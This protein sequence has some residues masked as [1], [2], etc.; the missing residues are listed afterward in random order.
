LTQERIDLGIAEVTVQFVY[1]VPHGAS[2]DWRLGAGMNFQGVVMN[3]TDLSRSID[4]YRE[5]LDFAVISQSDQL[6]AVRPPGGDLTQVIVLRAQGSS[7]VG[8]ARH[9]GLR[10]FVLEVDSGGQLEEFAS[11]LE[12][13]KLLVGRREH[14]EWTAVVG[15]DV[16]GV[17]F[18]LATH[19]G[20]GRISEDSWKSL[21][22]FLYGVGE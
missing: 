12:S 18:V 10:A 22:D 5:V 15:R 1:G 8:G 19:A 4:F 3:V 20:P 7:P 2:F 21:D 11:R 17:T 6:A 9:I 14:S 16:D 13:R